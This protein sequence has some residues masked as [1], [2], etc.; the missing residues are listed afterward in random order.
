M[1]LS[2]LSVANR[3]PTRPVQIIYSSLINHGRQPL[4]RIMRDTGLNRRQ[5]M[6][7]LA[8]LIQQHLIY[9]FTSVDD[10]LTYYEANWKSTYYFARCGK[11]IQVTKER[12]GGYA[13]TVMDT[14]LRLGHTTVAQ[15]ETLPELRVKKKQAV[16]RA[17]LDVGDGNDDNKDSNNDEDEAL[18]MD[19]QPAGA[20]ADAGDGGEQLPTAGEN[21]DIMDVDMDG[22]GEGEGEEDDD[23]EESAAQLHTTLSLLASHACIMRVRPAH[24]QSPGDLRDEVENALRSRS[25]IRAL[26]GKRQDDAIAQGIELMT[27]ERLDGRIA[28]PVPQPVIPVSGLKRKADDDDDNGDIDGPRKRTKLQ[29]GMAAADEGVEDEDEDDDADEG[30]GLDVSLQDINLL[31][32]VVLAMLILKLFRETW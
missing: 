25:D 27:K 7:G 30:V 11:I 4:I 23:E 21:G 9:H 16:P 3:S 17:K 15:L 1:M 31:S 14:I 6:Y 19:E 28:A 22:G 24:F 20:G 32:P 18:F 2:S 12:F 8:V 5:V 29:D 10:G 13:A 26:K